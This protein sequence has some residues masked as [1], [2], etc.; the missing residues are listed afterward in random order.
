MLAGTSTRWPTMRKRLRSSQA[1]L[2]PGTISAPCFRH[3]TTG[4]AIR[5]TRWRWRAARLC[6]AHKNLGN[7]L[8]ALNRHQE[9]AVYFEQAWLSIQMISKLTSVLATHCSSWSGLTRPW[10]ISKKSL[11]STLPMSMLTTSRQRDA[12][13]RRSEQAIVHYQSALAIKPADVEATASSETH[14]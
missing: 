11:R 7:A 14:F 4:R 13:A 3:W 9:A 6:A 12:Y 5:T 2:K 8:G 1:M 10:H